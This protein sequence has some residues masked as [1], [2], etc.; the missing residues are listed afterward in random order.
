MQT[1]EETRW[2]YFSG[3]DRRGPV[4]GGALME[5]YRKGLLKADTQ[6]WSAGYANW[7]ALQQTPFF[8]SGPMSGPPPVSGNAVNNTMVWWLAFMPILGSIIEYI[9]ATAVG[10]GSQS[11]WFVTFFLNVWLC[12]LDCKRL[13]AAGYD[14]KTL[15]SYWLIPVYLFKRAKLLAQTPSYAIVWVVT[16]VVMLLA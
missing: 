11:L 13:R 16:F 4:S 9:I 6:V 14:T 7:I 5:L 3:D 2:Y 15:G 8:Q 12:S 10:A 1:T